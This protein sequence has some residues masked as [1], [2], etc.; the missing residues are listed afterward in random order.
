[1][2]RKFGQ[3]VLIV[4]ACLACAPIAAMG[5]TSEKPTQPPSDPMPFAGPLASPKFE[6]P[7]MRLCFETGL[8]ILPSSR[9]RL[10]ETSDWRLGIMSLWSIGLCG[11]Y[12]LGTSSVGAFVAFADAGASAASIGPGVGL[13][14]YV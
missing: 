5:Q 4:L 7:S 12:F 3:R 1:M 11:D 14:W 6:E 13:N 9:L 8:C 10:I 2:T